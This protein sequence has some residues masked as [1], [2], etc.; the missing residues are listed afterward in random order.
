MDKFKK[1]TDN[2]TAQVTQVV[3][4]L[5]PLKLKTIINLQKPSRAILVT[6]IKLQAR[7]KVYRKTMEILCCHKMMFLAETR[8]KIGKL[9]VKFKRKII[10]QV[11][12]IQKAL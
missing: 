10:T 8:G 9:K 6:T 7:V 2:L 5:K 1:K 12:S 3:D 4:M 11:L